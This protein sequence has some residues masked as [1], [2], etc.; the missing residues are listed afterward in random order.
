MGEHI[1][2]GDPPI[3]VTL[4][5][6]ARARRLS[7]RVSRLDGRVTLTMPKGLGDAEG[8]SFAREKQGWL[9][10]QLSRAVAPVRPGIGGQVPFGGQMHDIVA[11]PGRQ[12]RRVDGRLEVPGAA[13]QVPARLA[14]FFKAEARDLLTDAADRYAD[15]LGREY[16]RITLRDTR[17]RWGSCTADGGLMFSWRLVMAPPNVLAYVAAHEVAHLVEMNHA[18]AFWAL[19]ETLFG[20][21]SE[22]RRW[23]RQKGD[24]LHGYRF[25]R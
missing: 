21:P 20:D 13:E 4:R 7:L 23:L 9:R 1:L 3:K 15:K 24:T 10:A 11:G 22:Q 8:L 17:S 2:P 16:A 6:S 5:R 18:P 12:V 19:V 25:H 14:G